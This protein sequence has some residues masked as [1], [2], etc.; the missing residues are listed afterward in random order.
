MHQQYSSC[1]Y[2]YISCANNWN[3]YI[4]FYI[5]YGD[6]AWVSFRLKSHTFR[7]F[8]QQLVQAN[9]KYSIKATY[10]WWFVMVI[11]Q[12][13]PTHQGP[14]MRKAIPCYDACM[15]G[16]DPPRLWSSLKT[17]KG[18]LFLQSLLGFP[19]ICKNLTQCNY[20]TGQMVNW[21]T[22]YYQ[23]EHFLRF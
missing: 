8:V 21:E 11:H 2:C 10:E 3:I 7:P 13:T 19:D 12:Y 16:T 5:Y 9:N 1:C 17:M 18:Y 14:V 20:I 4:Y 22:T 6:A 15:I 23:M